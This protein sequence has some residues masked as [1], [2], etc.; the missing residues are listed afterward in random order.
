MTTGAE[1]G[2]PPCW[3]L[4]YQAEISITLDRKMKMDHT[5]TASGIIDAHHGRTCCIEGVPFSLPDCDTGMSVATG[6]IWVE[7]NAELYINR[8]CLPEESN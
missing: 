5:W 6:S 4:G 8:E 2:V 7:G 1:G 3:V